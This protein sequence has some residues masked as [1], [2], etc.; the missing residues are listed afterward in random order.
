MDVGFPFTA[1]ST[2][3]ARSPQDNRQLEHSW[4]N[5]PLN[6][7]AEGG[8]VTARDPVEIDSSRIKTATCCTFN[9]DWM[10]LLIW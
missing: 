1:Y 2:L 5:Q 4:S 6:G 10:L 3:H 8:G 9:T 7:E